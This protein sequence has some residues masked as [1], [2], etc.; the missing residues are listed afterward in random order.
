MSFHTIF[1]VLHEGKAAV[2]PS[3]SADEALRYFR[4]YGFRG[5]LYA[6]YCS[7]E[8]AVSVRETGSLKTLKQ[9]SHSMMKVG[10]VT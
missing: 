6:C 9:L 8:T 5:E 2:A 1:V 10:D 7:A 3:T 4:D